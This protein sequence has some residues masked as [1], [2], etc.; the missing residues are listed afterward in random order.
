MT[1]RA[2]VAALAC[3][4]KARYTSRNEA[5]HFGKVGNQQRGGQQRQYHCQE[6]DGWHNTSM[7]KQQFRQYRKAISQREQRYA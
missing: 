3:R 1:T 2:V 5:K 7:P 6:C 4:F